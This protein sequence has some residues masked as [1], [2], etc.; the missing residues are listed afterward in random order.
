MIG[1]YIPG[2][3]GVN[4]KIDTKYIIVRVYENMT[5]YIHVQKNVSSKGCWFC[6]SGCIIGGIT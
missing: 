3:Y 6:H 4:D 2:V 1:R 5:S